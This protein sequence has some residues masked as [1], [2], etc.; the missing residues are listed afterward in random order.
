MPWFATEEPV[1]TETS[2]SVALRALHGGQPEHSFERLFSEGSSGVS[3]FIFP[4]CALYFMPPTSG[5]ADGF[6]TGLWRSAGFKAPKQLCPIDWRGGEA[7]RASADLQQD[8]I[9]IADSEP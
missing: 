9:C 1:E 2:T 3:N 5:I 7:A 6:N 4:L 8:R